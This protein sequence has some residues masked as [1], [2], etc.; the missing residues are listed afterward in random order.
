VSRRKTKKRRWLR[1]IVV[2][3]AVPLAV[4]SVAFLVWLFWLDLAGRRVP[5]QLSESKKAVGVPER[6]TG[7]HQGNQ[8]SQQSRERIADEDRRKLNDILEQR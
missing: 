4:W 8:S 3:V 7:Q 6:K 5:A 2:F 1:L